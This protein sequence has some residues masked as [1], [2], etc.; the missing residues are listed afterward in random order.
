ME[1]LKETLKK[2]AHKNYKYIELLFGKQISEN[3][4]DSRIPKK[5]FLKLLEYFKQKLHNYNAKVI[6]SKN[7]E[8]LNKRLNINEEFQ[9]RCFEQTL[10][11]KQLM[12][13]KE[14]Q[15]MITFGEKKM[16]SI[17]NFDISKEYDNVN[18][19]EVVSYNINN[20]FYLNFI[21]NKIEEKNNDDL[22]Y[23][24]ISIYI[25]KKNGKVKDIITQIEIYLNVIY[26]NLKMN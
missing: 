26:E 9:Q 25:T 12:N 15:Y 19:K 17:E 3:I 16:I 18:L 10:I 1:F 7:Y 22:I 21:T 13:F 20:K 11:E 24:N 4:Y 14:N 23:Y 6:R 2:I 5:T 8:I